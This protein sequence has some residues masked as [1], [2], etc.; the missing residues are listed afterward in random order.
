MLDVLIKTGNYIIIILLD[1]LLRKI[2][3]FKEDFT[4]LPKL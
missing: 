2:V 1:M 3:F 4:V